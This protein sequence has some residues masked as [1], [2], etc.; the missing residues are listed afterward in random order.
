MERLFE[1]PLHPKVFYLGQ[2]GLTILILLA[3]EGC[4]LDPCLYGRLQSVERHCCIEGVVLKHV[5]QCWQAFSQFAKV[6]NC[7]QWGCL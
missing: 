2:Q 4:C 7:R 6:L 1:H 3:C 5:L